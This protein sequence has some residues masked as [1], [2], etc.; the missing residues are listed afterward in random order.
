ML[1]TNVNGTAVFVTDFD[2]SDATIAIAITDVDARIVY[3]QSNEADEIVDHCTVKSA[4]IMGAVKAIASRA[5]DGFEVTDAL[6]ELVSG[7]HLREIHEIDAKI[8]NDVTNI[9]GFLT[10]IGA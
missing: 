1:Y 5:A 9:I 3:T 7:F 6:R 2:G 8:G 4:L 10:D